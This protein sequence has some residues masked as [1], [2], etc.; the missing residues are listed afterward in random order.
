[1]SYASIG[2]SSLRNLLE[3]EGVLMVTEG[4][5]VF[6]VNV[7]ESLANKRIADS[8][9]RQRTGC[10]VVAISDT[11]GRRLLP[12]PQEVIPPD[13]QLLLIGSVEAEERFLEQFGGARA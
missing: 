13:A 1:M 6:R 11:E 3:R 7:P 5:D 8:A 2:A 10:N 9:I 12:A 4:L